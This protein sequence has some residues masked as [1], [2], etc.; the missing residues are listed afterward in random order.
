MEIKNEYDIMAIMKEEYNEKIF[1]TNF[2]EINQICMKLL[3]SSATMIAGS[4]MIIPE[5][6][7]WYGLWYKPWTMRIRHYDYE[8]SVSQIRHVD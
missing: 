5:A 3:S 1:I 6:S 2:D 7:L 4:L 8:I